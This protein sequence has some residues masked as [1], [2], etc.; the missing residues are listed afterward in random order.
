ML[1]ACEQL[2]RWFGTRVMPRGVLGEVSDQEASE[3]AQLWILRLCHL[4]VDTAGERAGNKNVD[5]V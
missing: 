2:H 3:A 5:L 1:L 4:N